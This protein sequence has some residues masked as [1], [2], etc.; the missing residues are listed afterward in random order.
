M[1]ALR[2]LFDIRYAPLLFAA[3]PQAYA[4]FLWLWRG[5]DSSTAAFWFAILGAIGF[6]SVYVG[7]I[8]WTEDGRLGRGATLTSLVALVF[9]VAVA[10]YVHRDQGWA[11][12]LHA[13]FPLT[14]F[15]YTMHMHGAAGARRAVAHDAQLAAE[16]AQ[17]L[18]QLDQERAYRAQ[19]AAAIAD[20]NEQLRHANAQPPRIVERAVEVPAPELRTLVQQMRQHDVAWRTIGAVVEKPESTV[21]RWLAQAD[22]IKTNGHLTGVEQ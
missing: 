13:G 9:S 17:V 15:A 2:T 21:R 16:H 22:T 19:D 12:L 5:S 4:I 10:I 1:R 14:A 6:E 3:A 7:A 18:A 8:A 20:L 11:S